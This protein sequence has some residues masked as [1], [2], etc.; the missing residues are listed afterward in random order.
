MIILGYASKGSVIGSE[1]A[2]ILTHLHLAFGLLTETGDI[3]VEGIELLSKL[4]EIREYNPKIKILVSI[5]PKGR[6]AFTRVAASDKLRK[7]LGE[8]CAGLIRDYGLDGV[9]FDWEYPCVPSNNM[10]SSPID[11]YNFTLM[12]RQVRQSLRELCP[13][14][15]PLLAIAAGADEYYVESVEMPALAEILDYVC[16]MTYDLKCG[17]HAL[18]GHHTALYSSTGDYFRNSC[19]RAINL[20]IN[21]GMPREKLLLG[22]AFYSRKWENVPAYNHG[23]L[24]LTPKGAGYGPGYTELSADYINKQGFTR[25]W[26]EEAK[27]P[28][29]FDGST[30]YSYDDEES[31]AHK[32]CYVKEQGL[33]GIFYWEHLSDPSLKLLRVMGSNI[34]HD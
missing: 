20:F 7:A 24:Q 25:Y 5:V 17:F 22:A 32:C 6:D 10:D 1:D 28:W 31:I 2:K 33:G 34:D 19:H 9:D 29:L 13:G 8:S 12:L 15:S 16:L 21:A 4:S 18:S 26:D 14:K 30:F 23:F 11:K 27:A 3:E